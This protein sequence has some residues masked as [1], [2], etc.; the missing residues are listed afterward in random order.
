MWLCKGLGFLFGFG[1]KLITPTVQSIQNALCKKHFNGHIVGESTKTGSNK[2]HITE[3]QQEMSLL[4]GGVGFLSEYT[5][6]FIATIHTYTDSM[7]TVEDIKIT[8]VN[9]SM[10]R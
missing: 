1:T 7:Q 6:Q 8:Q 10:E 5:Y 2:R 3:I 4:I 9:S